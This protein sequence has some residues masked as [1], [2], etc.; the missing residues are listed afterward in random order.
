MGRGQGL[1]ILALLQK[2]VLENRS[3]ATAKTSPLSSAPQ[4]AFQASRVRDAFIASD[5]EQGV[6]RTLISLFLPPRTTRPLKPG[7]GRVWKLEK[8]ESYS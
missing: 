1:C 4:Q 3:P 2:A 8:E 5:N 7:E 6:C